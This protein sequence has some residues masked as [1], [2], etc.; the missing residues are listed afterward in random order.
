MFVTTQLLHIRS[1]FTSQLDEQNNKS[2]LL[3]RTKINEYLA[4]AETLKEHLND[5]KPAKSAVGLTGGG[6]KK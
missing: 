6:G 2:K 3:I 1:A 5:A 4:R